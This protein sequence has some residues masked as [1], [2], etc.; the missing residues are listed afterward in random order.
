MSEAAGMD[1]AAADK[2]EIKYQY[3][4]FVDVIYQVN[5]IGYKM[6]IKFIVIETRLKLHWVWYK[7]IPHD[8]S[9]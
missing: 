1:G 3:E 5:F 6:C 4:G 8:D 7:Q 2:T 9:T